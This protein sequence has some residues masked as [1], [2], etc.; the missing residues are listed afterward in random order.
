MS[1]DRPAFWLT[2]L[3]SLSPGDR[4]CCLY[5]GDAERDT[6]LTST[7]GHYRAASMEEAAAALQ[8]LAAA[9][10]LYCREQQADCEPASGVRAS[11]QGDSG[12]GL[13]TAAPLCLAVDVPPAEATA[14]EELEAAAAA[15]ATARGCAAVYLYDRRLF[16]PAALLAVIERHQWVLVGNQVLPNPYYCP[17]PQ[18]DEDREARILA[19]RLAALDHAAS[20]SRRAAENE[21]R[22]RRVFETSPTG[23][24]VFD[25]DG[26]LIDANPADLE[27]YGIPR[28]ADVLGFDLF[29]VP[30]LPPNARARLAAGEVLHFETLPDLGELSSTGQLVTTKSGVEY[31]DILVVSLGE[32]GG[33][34]AQIQDITDR[35][36]AEQALSQREALYRSIIERT[37]MVVYSV[38]LGSA[39]SGEYA[40]PQIWEMLGFSAEEWVTETDLWLRQIHPEDLDR[41]RHAE[42]L[43]RAGLSD[44]SETYRFFSRDGRLVW[45][46]DQAQLVHDEKGRAVA[47]QGVMVDITA[48]KQA[49]AAL[50]RSERRLHAILHTTQEGY[51]LV[52][53]DSR[54]LDV[55]D[56][57]CQMSGY[58]REE[59]LGLTVATVEAEEDPADVAA[60]ISIIIAN[61]G[62]VF[63][64]RHRR[65]DGSLFSVSVAT[66]VLREEGRDLIFAFISDTTELKRA[67]EA[68]LGSEHRYRSLVEDA[69]VIIYTR[70]L[71]H[72]EV[73]PYVSPIIEQVLGWPVE[74]WTDAQFYKRV[75]HPD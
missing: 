55:N 5:E 3:A 66:K 20:R 43:L 65:K 33:Y 24:E 11:G 16:P 7:L 4:L 32:E 30:A 61:D 49:E 25:A 64:S 28:L 44:F 14:V 47:Y 15:Y 53:A 67:V 54:Y 50:R 46:Q 57:Y 69:P 58:S 21:Q 41:V 12:G 1:A 13:P 10:R 29:T 75:L 48:Q 26:H 71:Q 63:E 17:P 19:H 22:Y 70:D 56:S 23:I 38:P 74:C 27:I 31:R 60:H 18:P 68:L 51:W 40:S 36:R 39:G 35:R 45:V 6:V 72:P 8:A 34:L 42:S 2:T 52:D 37:P 62:D 73:P 9:G 59:L